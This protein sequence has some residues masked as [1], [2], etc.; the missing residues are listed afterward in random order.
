MELGKRYF[1]RCSEV[2]N[3]IVDS[4]GH[5]WINTPEERESKKQKYTQVQEE[6]NKAYDE[7]KE[8]YEKSQAIS[9]S[10]S[11]TSGVVNPYKPVQFSFPK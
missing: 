11:S 10:S 2:L 4:E 8:E 9:S 1:P 7:D 3:K 5:Q 6:V